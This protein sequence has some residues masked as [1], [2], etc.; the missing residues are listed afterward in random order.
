M[1]LKAL[2]TGGSGTLGAEL[3]KLSD[4][5][6]QFYSPSS[7]EC[8][9]LNQEQIEKCFREIDFT[10]VVHCAASTNVTG[11]EKHPFEAVQTNIIGTINIL[12]ECIRHNRKLVFISTD[13]VFDGE[14]GKYSTDDPINPLSKYAMTKASAELAVRTY[15]NSLVIRT[16]FYAHNFPYEKA[17][18]DQWT[19]KDYV[20][21]IAPKVV[22]AVKSRKTGIVHI[23]SPR[24][25]VYEIAIERRHDVRPITLSDIDFKIPKDVSLLL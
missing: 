5:T 13:Y 10:T 8:N 19:S 16:S 2:L 17:F 1:V 18:I 6:L 25:S 7:S 9:I 22:D 12:R 23:G 24:R 21:I 4:D 20:D 11:I 15:D 3:K 14:K